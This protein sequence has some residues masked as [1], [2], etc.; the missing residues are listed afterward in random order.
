MN[1]E[2]AMKVADAVLYEGYMLYPYRR[3]ALKN[4]QRWA[5]GTLYPPDYEEVRRGTERSSM[6]SE[7]LLKS[8]GGARAEVQLRF[9]QLVKRAGL[10]RDDDPVVFGS[11]DES[12]ERSVKIEIAADPHT[13]KRFKFI[14]SDGTSEEE[15]QSDGSSNHIQGAVSLSAKP[16]EPNLLKLIIEVTNETLLGSGDH[17]R[18]QAL[19]HAFLMAHLILEA[20]GGEFV[21]LLD[22]PAELR[23]HISDCRNL[24]NFPVLLGAEHEHEMMLCSPIILYDHPQI[25]PESAG[26]FFDCTEMDEML[27]LRV[28]TLT[29]DEKQEVQTTDERLRTLLERTEQSAREQLSKTHGVI[30]NLRSGK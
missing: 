29:D 12:I 6:H 3:S 7:C 13:Y 1:R 11:E 28:M 17:E 9:L 27:T 15:A 24:G 23:A 20:K 22:P 25:A 30:R 2:L 5:F 14:F 21:S 4:R 19:L 10:E 8:E 16:V 18:H 26:D